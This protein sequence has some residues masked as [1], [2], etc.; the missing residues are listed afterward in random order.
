VV[1]KKIK[2]LL[3]VV[4]ERFFKVSMAFFEI[5]KTKFFP[6]VELV[7][8]WELGMSLFSQKIAI[9]NNL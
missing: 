2:V 3:A 7:I 1:A 8:M 4:S 6:T 5:L 9:A